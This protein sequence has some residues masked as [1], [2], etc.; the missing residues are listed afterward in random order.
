M[1][2][3]LPVIIGN[4]LVMSGDVILI[5]IVVSILMI[6]VM[7]WLIRLAWLM[8]DIEITYVCIYR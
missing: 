6:D 7:P 1:V 5:L 8:I 3:L 4:V 2:F